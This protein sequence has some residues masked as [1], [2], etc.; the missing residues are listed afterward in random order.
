MC[1]ITL[2]VQCIVTLCSVVGSKLAPIFDKRSKQQTQ[3]ER[4]P[5]PVL[6]EAEKQAL[7]VRRAFLTS[8]VP[9]ELKRQQSSV[10]VLDM[11]TLP[12]V[13][14]PIDSHIQQ[15]P[16]VNGI[17]LPGHCDPWSLEGCDLPYGK[18]VAGGNVSASASLT[19]GLLT[20]VLVKPIDYNDEVSVV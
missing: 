16:T 20:D 13:I 12:S 3:P 1:I 8:G 7:E 5:A 6:T 18:S 4:K 9:E 19:L 10:V 17:Q 14:W 15:K 2:I 11:D